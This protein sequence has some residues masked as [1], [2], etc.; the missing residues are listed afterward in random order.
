MSNSTQNRIDFTFT[1]AQATVIMDHLN[2]IRE[3]LPPIGLTKKERRTM[4]AANVENKAF[5][6]NAITSIKTSTEKV[7]PD[8][9]K[10]EAMERDMVLF[11]QIDRIQS[12]MGVL[13]LQFSDIKRVAAHE[14]YGKALTTHRLYEIASQSGV[15]GTKT[16]YDLMNARFKNPNRG[17]PSEDLA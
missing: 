5:I 13:A 6:E 8:F 1:D 16:G 15:P 2:A 10:L 4:Y 9:I 12:L 7:V 17:R 11:E 14:A 3:M